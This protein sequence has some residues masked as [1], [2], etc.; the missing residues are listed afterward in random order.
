MGKQSIRA[1]VSI[2]ADAEKIVLA[3]IEA[4][5]DPKEI[6]FLPSQESR[7]GAVSALPSSS[8]RN[9]RTENRIPAMSAALTIDIPKLEKQTHA[10]EGATAGAAT[11]CVIGGVFGLLVGFGT[12]TIPSMGSLFAAGP[13]MAALSGIGAGGC[14]GG[15]LGALIGAGIPEKQAQD[16]KHKMIEGN[17]LIEISARDEQKAKQIVE[18]MQKNR[19]QNISETT[20]HAA[21]LLK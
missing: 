14:I 1:W 20:I 2:R 11:G 17:I 4:G 21:T 12:L 15:I 18:I 10:A 13:L 7:G 16:D 6:S 9:W 8:S 3:C 19:A 5:I